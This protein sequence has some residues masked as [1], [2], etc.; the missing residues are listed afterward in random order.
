MN[1]QLLK[2]AGFRSRMFATAVLLTTALALTGI[3]LASLNAFEISDG[4]Q[5]R[6]VY[7]FTK[8]PMQAAALLGY[9]EEDFALQEEKNMPSGLTQV[10]LDKKFDVDVFADGRMCSARTA[11]ATV[12]EILLENGIVLGADDETEPARDTL[13]T[14]KDSIRVVRVE[15]EIKTV[16]EEIPYQTVKRMTDALTIGEKRVAQQ[17][18][19]GELLKTIEVTRRDGRETGRVEL[20]RQIMRQPQ[21]QILEHGTAGAVVTRGGESLRYKQVLNVTATAYTTYKNTKGITATGTKARVGAIAVDPKVIPLG[22]RLYITSEDGK[23]W[24]YGTAVAEDTGG[25]I[26]GK[27]IDLYFNTVS[28]CRQF[29]VRKAKV[30]IL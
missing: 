8:D 28:E 26:K 9:T 30:Y 21:D 6:R 16:S 23:S 18:Q 3:L 10:F 17:G 29:G 24:V 14:K 19:A 13:I 12:S 22:S 11:K 27:K 7:A 1:K 20:S 4:I 25:V 2:K 15:K 5:T